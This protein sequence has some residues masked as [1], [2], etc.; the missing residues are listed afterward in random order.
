MRGIVLYPDGGVR[1]T[2]P[3]PAGYGIHGYHY[4]ITNKAKSIGLGS[5]VATSVGYVEK[6]EVTAIEEGFDY[7]KIDQD[8]YNSS[9]LMVYPEKY[10]ELYGTV[11][12]K[13]GEEELVVH[14]SNNRA[15]LYA[16]IRSL[17]YVLDYKPKFVTILT[18]SEQ[19]VKGYNEWLVGWYK[20]NWIRQDGSLVANNDLWK[21][22]FFLSEAVKASEIITIVK[23]V[24]GHNGDP[25]NTRA[26]K[27]ATIASFIASKGVEH[28]YKQ[29]K[30]SEG[31][32]K[33]TV[34]KHP[35]LNTKYCY[36]NT[37]E[38]ANV[39]GVYYLGNHGKL[40]ELYGNRISDATAS[41]VR[42]SKPDNIIEL[43]RQSQSKVT[44]YADSLFI[45]DL[46][47]ITQSSVYNDINTYGEL[48]FNPHYGY[49]RNIVL[50]DSSVITEEINPARLSARGVEELINLS[51]ILDEFLQD[52]KNLT[53]TDITDSIYE[54][55]IK[56]KSKNNKESEVKKENPDEIIYKLKNT[57]T[58]GCPSIKI[59]G[60][61]LQKGE[62]KIDT[63]V[64]TTNIDIPDRNALKRLEEYKPK[65]Y[66]LTYTEDDFVYRY[67][68]VIKTD[69]DIGIWAGIY[70]NTRVFS[71]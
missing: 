62:N 51:S 49:N 42:L 4:D 15:E 9:K 66:F 57:I 20:R 26:D 23:W 69:E 21:E 55:S 38:N 64:L 63:F 22:I 29:Y 1:P 25:G 35:F 59:Q 5:I 47:R 45:A 40:H 39:P 37:S 48:L 19:T 60:N 7:S 13:I 50:A 56:P 52:K 8:F 14:A 24:R 58:V 10:V 18:D 41:V 46:S 67:A 30:E 28:H 31:F 17:N 32:W 12:T 54:K 43:I 6:E 27:L 65:V 3:G 16:L 33:T 34:D 2:N 68:T 71:H 70:S 11:T 36:F 44:N 53:V 61:Y